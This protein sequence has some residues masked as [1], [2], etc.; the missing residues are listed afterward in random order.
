MSHVS[1]RRS[2]ARCGSPQPP[3]LLG[4]TCGPD[5]EP[6]H[7]QSRAGAAESSCLFTPAD[8]SYPWPLRSYCIR[9]GNPTR[10]TCA[11]KLCTRTVATADENRKRFRPACEREDRLDASVPPVYTSPEDRPRD[12]GGLR[13]DRAECGV[14]VA[15]TPRG[16]LLFRVAG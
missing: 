1:V 11:K 15:S 6:G 10:G 13:L 9:T 2:I 5:V 8:G 3:L 12:F 14:E 4:L 7:L 16:K